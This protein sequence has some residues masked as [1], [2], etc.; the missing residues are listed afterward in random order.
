MTRGQWKAKK[1]K[2]TTQILFWDNVK[3]ITS[4]NPNSS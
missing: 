2:P 4:K 1:T 3:I